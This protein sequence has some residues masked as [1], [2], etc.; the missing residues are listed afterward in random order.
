MASKRS[1]TKDRR[2]VSK[3][4][5]ESTGYTSHNPDQLILKKIFWSMSISTEF[6]ICIEIQG[7]ERLRRSKCNQTVPG[8][9]E[10]FPRPVMC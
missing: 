4:I 1:C 2:E 3:V 9:M 6:Q 5:S 8:Y 10:R 7:Q